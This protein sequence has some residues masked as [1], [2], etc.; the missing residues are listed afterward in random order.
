M[1]NMSLSQNLHL[2]NKNVTLELKI[3]VKDIKSDRDTE[4]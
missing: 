4:I 2:Y 1:N 3:K